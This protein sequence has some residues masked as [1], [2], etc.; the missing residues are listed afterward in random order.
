MGP[1]A[2]RDLFGAFLEVRFGSALKAPMVGLE[3]GV[4]HGD[5]AAQVLARWRGCGGYVL[6]DG[7]ADPK[8]GAPDASR[9]A[10]AAKALAPWTALGGSNV[11]SFL[12]PTPLV[13]ANAAMAAGRASTGEWPV[14]AVVAADRLARGAAAH[15]SSLSFK[16]EEDESS[17]LVAFVYID[18]PPATPPLALRACLE[19]AWAALASG[20]VLAGHD[21][22][23][24]RASVPRAVRAF[25]RDAGLELLLTDV[26]APR[27]DVRGNQVP[28][29][30]PSW[31]FIKS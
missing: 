15:V 1:V 8:T 16:S 6:L 25:A 31:Y 30:C 29:C 3:V 17:P 14:E 24:A 5:F 21:Y 4:E 2:D 22:T 18:L 9:Q 12:D 26:Q 19:A 7:F 27:A 13:A 20:G 23:A 10:F 28:P 11:A